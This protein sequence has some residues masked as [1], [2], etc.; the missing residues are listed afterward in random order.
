MKNQFPVACTIFARVGCGVAGLLLAGCAGQVYPP[1]GPRDTAPPAI[2]ATSPDTNAVRVSTD[3]ITLS[4]SEYVDRRSVEE[5]IFISPYVGSL[6]FDW[7]GTEVAITFSEPLKRNRTYVVSVGTD[8]KDQREGN[9]MDAGFTLAFSTGDSI[10]R[11]SIAGRVFDDKPEGVMV[12]AYACDSTDRDSVNPSVRKPDYITQTGKRGLFTLSNLATGGYRVIAVRDEYKDLL[13]DKQVDAYGVTAEDITLSDTALSVRDVW[14][15]LATEDTARPF[16]SSAVSPDRRHVLARFS[17]P[18]DSLTFG[19]ALFAI[20][21]TLTGTSVGIDERY[22]IPGLPATAGLVTSTPLDSSAGYRLRV[23]G[24]FDRAGNGIDTT[25]NTALFGAT[26]D[27]DSTSPGFT[28]ADIRDSVRAVPVDRHMVVLFSEPVNRIAAAAAFRLVKDSSV[29]VPFG[30]SW[31]DPVSLELIPK[32]PLTIKTWYVLTATL[33]SIRDVAGNA[34]RDSLVR[35]AFE[36][37]DPRLAGT[38]EGAIID[39]HPWDIRGDIVVEA[40]PVQSRHTMTGKIRLAEVGPF[41]FDR[42]PEGGYTIDAYRDRDSS[43]NYSYGQP[44]PFIPSERF[45]VLEDTLKV[46]ARWGVEGVQ[47]R[48]R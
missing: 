45:V 23:D 2:V 25:N 4:F 20:V 19:R 21:D 33:D 32:K 40:H 27:I 26:G 16:L 15:R 8:V 35:I 30:I 43:G 17:E 47:L 3:E 44:F 46:R 28:V 11:G 7:S 10:D 38:I 36:T 29:A 13:Y 42:L 24:V 22:L 37:F 39:T 41:T 14:F 9:R 1:G 12:F 6:S 5:S 18:V 48:L 31:K 34:F